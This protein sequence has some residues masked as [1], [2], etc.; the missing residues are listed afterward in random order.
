VSFSVPDAVGLQAYLNFSRKS[1]AGWSI[2]NILL[3]LTGGILSFGQQFL[4]AI[5]SGNWG[6]VFGSPVKV[7]LGVVSVAFDI[8]FMIQ[9]YCLYRHS[10]TNMEKGY[11]TFNDDGTL[12]IADGGEDGTGADSL[13]HVPIMSHDDVEPMVPVSES[14]LDLERAP[15]GKEH[16]Q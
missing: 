14:I 5:N 16:S 3:D 7:G 1:T 8:V 13:A 4:D 12:T 6:V 15:I 2:G 9:H 10:S 11:A